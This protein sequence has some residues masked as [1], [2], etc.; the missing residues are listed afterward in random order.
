MK[1]NQAFIQNTIQ[2]PN[3]PEKIDT[4]NVAHAKIST[5]TGTYTTDMIITR[6][7]MVALILVV[8]TELSL[9][10]GSIAES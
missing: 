5:G 10:S 1:E 2:G 7:T 6:T 4:S 9:N 8:F 3:H